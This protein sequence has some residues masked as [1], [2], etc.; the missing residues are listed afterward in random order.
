MSDACAATPEEA[1]QRFWR[2]YGPEVL[3]LLLGPTDT[4]YLTPSNGRRI[5]RLPYSRQYS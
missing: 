2:R 4:P 1:K 5:F 3:Q